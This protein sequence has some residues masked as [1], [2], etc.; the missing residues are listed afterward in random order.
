MSLILNLPS[1][2][3]SGAENPLSTIS[4]AV[5]ITSSYDTGM[6]SSVSTS[7]I[8]LTSVDFDTSQGLMLT[9]APDNDALL[10]V[11]NSDVT[12]AAA[13][14]TSGMILDIG[15]SLFFSASNPNVVYL[16]A[17]SGT[18]TVFWLAV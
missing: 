16:I 3:I 9:S 6:N 2:I 17:A 10:Y 13:D 14:A 18:Q 1:L 8:V 11:G 5:G 12:A 7:A 15:E 4:K